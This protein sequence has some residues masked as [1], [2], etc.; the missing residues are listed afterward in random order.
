VTAPVTA[1]ARKSGTI[2]SQLRNTALL[3]ERGRNIFCPNAV[4][5][6]RSREEQSPYGE[7]ATAD[8][9]SGNMRRPSCP[10]V[11]ISQRCNRFA[12]THCG[13]ARKIR[14]VSIICPFV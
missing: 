3:P 8:L 4:L 10:L 12:N 2:K 14:S 1:V 9:S 5:N 13:Y 7:R 11:E 6:A